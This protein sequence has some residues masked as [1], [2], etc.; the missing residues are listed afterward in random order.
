MAKSN[1]TN[2]KRDTDVTIVA[3]DMEEN[4]VCSHLEVRH[5]Y[6]GYHL[7]SDCCEDNNGFEN[8]D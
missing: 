7:D 2:G 5:G 6:D 1:P 3:C 4:H 8:D